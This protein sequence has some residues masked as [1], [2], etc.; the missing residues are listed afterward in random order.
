MTCGD[1]P[2][3]PQAGTWIFDR[4]NWCPGYLVQPEIFDLATT[5]GK[6]QIIRF[7]M[8]P[9]TATKQ[10]QG[11]QVISAYLIQYQ[12]LQHVLD[13]SIEDIVAPSIKDIYL[14]KNPAAANPQIILKN[15]GKETI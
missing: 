1:N 10:N 15:N 3:Y 5:S 12:Q 6:E 9:Y 13:I 7:I 11:K 14:R 2:L 8:E 4:A